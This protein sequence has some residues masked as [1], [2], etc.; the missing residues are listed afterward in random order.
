MEI[1][2][3]YTPNTRKMEPTIRSS[4]GGLWSI[5]FPEFVETEASSVLRLIS[6]TSRGS[7]FPEPANEDTSRIVNTTGYPR[8]VMVYKPT[9]IDNHV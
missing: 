7:S 8:P 9:C 2:H 1:I 4:A 5:T 6:V 3:A